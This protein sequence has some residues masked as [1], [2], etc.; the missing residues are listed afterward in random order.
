MSPETSTHH[1]SYP[2]QAEILVAGKELVTKSDRV[3]RLL[4]ET[5]LHHHKVAELVGCSRQ[6]VNK[7]AKQIGIPAPTSSS[8]RREAVIKAHFGVS[9]KAAEHLNRKDFSDLDAD[10]LSKMSVRHAQVAGQEMVRQ[11]QK[12]CL[13]IGYTPHPLAVLLLMQADA[14]GSPIATGGETPMASARMIEAADDGELVGAEEFM[15][16]NARARGRAW[17]GEDVRARGGG[18]VPPAGRAKSD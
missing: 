16:V 15:A 2:S 10:S 3:A 4:V 5:T 17:G 6:L 14:I 7:V 1:K 12:E 18:D 13:H 11:E 8:A 9:L